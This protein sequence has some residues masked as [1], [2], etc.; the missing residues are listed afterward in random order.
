[1]IGPVATRWAV[2]GVVIGAMACGQKPEAKEPTAKTEPPKDS[3]ASKDLPAS[4]RPA[5]T[6]ESS[7]KVGGPSRMPT[8]EPM[9]KS[10]TAAASDDM[11]DISMGQCDDLEKIVGKLVFNDLTAKIAPG[12]DAAKREKS[13]KDA[14]EMAKKTGGQFGDSCRSGMAG[15]SIKR[16]TL[17]CMFKAK[18]FATFEGCNR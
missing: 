16:D 17:N 8:A 12:L 6:E 13:E 11:T 1:M 7:R 9:G 2:L 15:K 14:S 5:P 3:P 4:Q 18:D 10:T